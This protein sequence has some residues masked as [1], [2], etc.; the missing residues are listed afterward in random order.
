R[1]LLETTNLSIEQLVERVGYSSQ[2]SLRRLFQKQ[3]SLSPSAYRIQ[4]RTDTENP[5]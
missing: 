2:S 3:L 4:H 1:L 5:S